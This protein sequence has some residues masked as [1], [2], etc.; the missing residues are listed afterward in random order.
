MAS[1]PDGLDKPRR[2]RLT[3]KTAVA[4]LAIAGAAPAEAQAP[5]TPRVETLQQAEDSK[6]VVAEVTK[7]IA[8]R[9]ALMAKLIKQNPGNKGFVEAFQK[10]EQRLSSVEAMVSVPQYVDGLK[11]LE[12]MGG[13]P[14]GF[15][16]VDPKLILNHAELQKRYE[17]TIPQELRG[18]VR[19]TSRDL[20]ELHETGEPALE[21]AAQLA[22]QLSSRGILLS[23]DELNTVVKA[24][25]TSPDVVD[26]I[27]RLHDE[28]KNVFSGGALA[29]I[30]NSVSRD[31]I[32]ASSFENKSFVEGYTRLLRGGI[33]GYKLTGLEMSEDERSLL[34]SRVA[35]PSFV[36]AALSLEDA[37][38]EY[39]HRFMQLLPET[40]A[41]PS[42]IANARATRELIPGMWPYYL[43]E[44]HK[45]FTLPDFQRTLAAVPA[46]SRRFALGFIHQETS[47]LATWNVMRQ[48]LQKHPGNKAFSDSL[49]RLNSARIMD[50]TYMEIFE[51]AFPASGHTSETSPWSTVNIVDRKYFEEKIGEDIFNVT[52]D[53]NKF[54]ALL[55]NPETNSIIRQMLELYT[56][57]AF[58]QPVIRMNQLHDDQTP[59]GRLEILRDMSAQAVFGLMTIGGDDAWLSTARLLY[60]GNGYTGEAAKNSFLPRVRSEYGSLP[61]FFREIRPDHKVFGTFLEFL[62]RN[63]ILD[64]FLTDV[65][66]AEE[67]RAVLREYL[68]EPSAGIS[69]SQA[70]TLSDLLNTTKSEGIRDFI[71][72]GLRSIQNKVLD[73]KD[74][75]S[76]IAGLLVA[77]Y[78]QGKK[79]PPEWA[80]AS[81]KEYGRY[82]PEIRDL[83]SEKVF[84]TEG[85]IARNIQVHVFYDDRGPDKPES[86]WDGH[87]SFRSYIT[88]LGGSV[89]W[90]KEG[91]IGRITVGRGY[92]LTDNGDYVTIRQADQRT[93]REIV[94][95]DIKPDRDDGTIK[96]VGEDLIKKERP[97]IVVHRGHSFHAP[98][99][100]QLIGSETAFVNLGSCGGAK[101]IS[102]V[103]E[104]APNAQVMATRGVGTMLVNDVVIP[105]LNSK[106]LHGGGVTWKTFGAQMTVEF[107]KRGGTAPQHWENYQTPDKNRIAHL[108]A[109]I[110][111]I[112]S[113][114]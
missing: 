89:E 14:A 102:D 105:S 113:R 28:H 101:N 97:Q 59:E 106:L 13:D 29:S 111:R 86:T 107:K 53:L 94:M 36:T 5:L 22:V 15:V 9:R 4:A 44:Y 39:W 11:L 17:R 2:N 110:K 103:L 50:P 76:Q 3:L 26:L 87:S 23:I 41:D 60:N 81:V 57:Q 80:H 6:D 25:A 65:G 92:E 98:K 37:G 82:F 31:L 88:S 49:M 64:K 48:A 104:K 75:S 51:R 38:Y 85:G 91:K 90:D 43:V 19:F 69:Q 35:D 95:Y 114:P 20:V 55:W 70:L 96:K 67:Q 12:G 63:N 62:S 61:A 8:V 99:T 27:V 66:T 32:N 40:Y 84:R 83:S 42:F 21:G 54:L 109:A 77:D 16:R 46:E 93:K 74:K 58:K 24:A 79:N 10:F 78:F 72:E 56:A 68:F 33:D 47:D 7:E 18:H 30:A 52:D 73:Q 1:G 100:I 45:A 112:Q 71:F 34:E 108:I